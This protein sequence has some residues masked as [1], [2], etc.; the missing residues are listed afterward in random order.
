M[1]GARDLRQRSDASHHKTIRLKAVQGNISFI[2]IV[3]NYLCSETRIKLIE[4]L[5]SIDD[6][7][8][9]S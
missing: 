6:V 9:W 4:T 7:W 1:L 8:V 2:L 5:I 3:S